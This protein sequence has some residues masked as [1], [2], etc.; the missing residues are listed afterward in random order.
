MKRKHH[1]II[2]MVTIFS[3]LAGAGFYC[4]HA[5]DDAGNV[6]RIR[7]TKPI[8]DIPVP[9]AAVMQDLNILESKMPNL[10]RPVLADQRPVNLV[11]LGHAP[12]FRKGNPSN[13]GNPEKG[14]P[15]GYSLTFAFQ[16]DRR[17][18]C[19]IDGELYQEGAELPDSA[20][21]L[22]IEPKRVLIKKK[23]RKNWLPLDENT[24]LIRTHK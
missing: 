19:V 21:I 12:L 2:S 14:T 7:L 16:S 1:G 15:L 3:A 22:K 4:L 8:P 24:H 6:G 23:G 11:P 10:T 18:L 13:G 20:R 17:R 5:L 9:S